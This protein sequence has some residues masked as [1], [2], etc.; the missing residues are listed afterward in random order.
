METRETKIQEFE[1]DIERLNKWISENPDKEQT[2]FY[3]LIVFREI[4]KQV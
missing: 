3:R 2:D 1:K 4:K